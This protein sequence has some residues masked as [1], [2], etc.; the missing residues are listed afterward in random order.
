MLTL[1]GALLVASSAN[2]PTGYICGWEKD[3]YVLHCI[4]VPSPNPQL[5]PTLTDIPLNATR[6]KIKSFSQRIDVRLN[7]SSELTHIRELILDTFNVTSAWR[8]IFRDLARISSLT[9]RNLVWRRMEKETFKELTNL[10][11]LSVEHLDA[12]EYLHPDLLRCLPALDSL[13][14][15][16][17]G[18]ATDRLMYA[19]YAAILR[20]LPPG[21]LRT[22]ALYAVHS[23]THP[24]T[25][26]NVDV[27]FSEGSSSRALVHLDLG[28]NNIFSVEGDP[29]R[30]WPV[31]EYV[32]LAGNSFLGAVF[33]TPFW[34]RF[35]THPRLKTV[36]LSRNNERAFSSGD[37][38][39]RSEPTYSPRDQLLSDALDISIDLSIT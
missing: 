19:D 16:H 25:K 37:A 2:C 14:F 30:C 7:F 26:L 17:V 3:I 31:V 13:S 36:D 21:R 6:L 23:D 18:A 9:L 11:S 33:V 8:E 12:L 1:C 27:L 10:R 28:R 15:R 35:Y 5:N 39:F 29:V 34:V 38:V 22:L 32:S 4:P 20:G 24:E